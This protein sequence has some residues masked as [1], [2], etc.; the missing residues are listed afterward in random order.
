V[1]A[2]AIVM[3][4]SGTAACDQRAEAETASPAAGPGHAST[5]S[6]RVERTGDGQD[7]GP[8]EP[9][10]SA[11]QKLAMAAQFDPRRPW[12]SPYLTTAEATESKGFY[13]QFLEASPGSRAERQGW[14]GYAR[15]VALER[16]RQQE[17]AQAE[18]VRLDEKASREDRDRPEAEELCRRYRANPDMSA[19]EIISIHER[20][21]Q[22]AIP[23]PSPL[24]SC[25]TSVRFS[26]GEALDRNRV[27]SAAPC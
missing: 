16:S 5:G 1:V 21:E 12:F 3:A 19:A 2:L 20:L 6:I 26:Y 13:I 8:L 18:A 22:L 23:Y 24:S 14:A 11:Q 25:A 7:P 4:A 10:P 9:M 15:Y 17:Y 27:C